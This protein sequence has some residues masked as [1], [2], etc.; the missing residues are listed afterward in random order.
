MDVLVLF[1]V[2]VIFF[3]LGALGSCRHLINTQRDRI[4]CLEG[5]HEIAWR[6]GWDRAWETAAKDDLWI[7][8]MYRDMVK[9]N[10]PVGCEDAFVNLYRHNYNARRNGS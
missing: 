3:M 10:A 1:L 8:Q 4:D 2:V 9:R 6:K 5:E 7:A